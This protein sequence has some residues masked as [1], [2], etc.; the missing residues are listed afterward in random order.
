MIEGL[1]PN[2]VLYN[3]F[4]RSL[5]VGGLGSRVRRRATSQVSYGVIINGYCKN[6]KVDRAWEIFEGMPL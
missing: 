2:V 4:V 6:K 5:C 3:S 1:F